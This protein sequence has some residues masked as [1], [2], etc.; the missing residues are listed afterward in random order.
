M[1]TERYHVS[2]T[3]TFYERLAAFSD[4]SGESIPSIIDRA[5]AHL[6]K[7][8]TA[9]VEV[10]DGLARRIRGKAI[11]THKTMGA[12]LDAAIV[13]FLDDAEQYPPKMPRVIAGGRKPA[14]GRCD[15]RRR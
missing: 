12:V 3:S 11:K 5:L 9:L 15:R 4:A 2:V 10:S 1:K 8:D 13:R 14:D 7:P 6:P